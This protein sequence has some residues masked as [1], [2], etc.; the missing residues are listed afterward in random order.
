MQKKLRGMGTLAYNS[1]TIG[2]VSS[3]DALWALIMAQPKNTRRTLT[4]RLLSE[5]IEAGEKLLLKASIERGWQQVTDM[6]RNGHSQGELQDLINELESLN[7][8]PSNRTLR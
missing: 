5:D 7:E 3:A 6:H 8:K 1:R 2:T 4:E